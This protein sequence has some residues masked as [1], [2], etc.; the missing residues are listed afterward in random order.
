MVERERTRDLANAFRE[1][2][3]EFLPVGMG[4]WFS[5]DALRACTVDRP[6]VLT[7]SKGFEHGAGVDLGFRS[8]AS[9]LCVIRAE[10]K[11]GEQTFRVAELAE[12]RPTKGAPL[13]PSAVV[14]AFASTA[15]RHGVS[16]LTAD[17]VYVEALREHARE[18]GLKIREAPSGQ[19]GKLAVYTAARQ[20]IAEGRVEFS[21]DHKRL[22]QQL[23]E[24]VG[25]PT[26]GG[27]FSI[28][29]PRKGGSHGDL[30]SAFVLALFRCELCAKRGNSDFSAIGIPSSWGDPEF[31]FGSGASKARVPLG[32]TDVFLTSGGGGHYKL[33]G[34][35]Y[36]ILPE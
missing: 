22:L 27:G 36:Y 29:S 18:H 25:R 1:F 20:L 32:A 30:A 2:D 5:L 11:P 34:Q 28:Q 15:T 21:S 19:A 9:A 4:V 3:V 33:N 13:V 16:E 17:L 24:V 10:G 23:R 8:D 14:A 12:Q 35:L 6:G 26:S 31:H 7:P